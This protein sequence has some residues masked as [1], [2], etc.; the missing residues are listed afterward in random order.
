M[1]DDVVSFWRAYRESRPDIA[2]PLAPPEAFAF[3]DSK[4]MADELGALV[5]RGVKL[6]TASALWC[7]SE[8][9]ALPEVGELA[10]VLNGHEQPLCVIKPTEVAVKPFYEVDEQFAHDE[11]EGD[12][13]LAYWRGAH[14]RFFSRTLAYVNRIFDEAMPV[15]CERFKVVFRQTVP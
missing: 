10:I 3:G 4:E 11:G 12:R 13:S 1:N 8:G 9:D 2:V 14:R 15:V 6:A 5:M 7:Y